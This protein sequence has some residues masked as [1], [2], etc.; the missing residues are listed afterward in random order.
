MAVRLCR[1]WGD[2]ENSAVEV[3]KLEQ[4][5]RGQRGGSGRKEEAD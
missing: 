5:A 2:V 4:V 1:V 3:R